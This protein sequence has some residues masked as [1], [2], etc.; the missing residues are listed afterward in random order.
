[1]HVRLAYIHIH[2][3]EMQSIVTQNPIAPH[4]IMHI[5]TP[6]HAI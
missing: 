6:K 3:E 4:K 2:T 1:M 5:N